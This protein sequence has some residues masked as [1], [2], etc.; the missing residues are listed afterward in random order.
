MKENPTSNS[1]LFKQRKNKKFGYKPRFQNSE[2][3]KGKED[4]EAKWEDV[5]LNSKRKGSVLKTLPVM[6]LMLIAIIVLM[7]IL[8]GYTK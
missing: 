1:N 4:F 3:L 6:I 7:Y 8:N 5:R 2:E